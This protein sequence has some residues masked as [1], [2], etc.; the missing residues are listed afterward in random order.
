MTWLALSFT[1]QCRSVIERCCMPGEN[2]M[3]AWRSLWRAH[4]SSS[5]LLSRC[6][7]RHCS[8]AF[9][10]SHHG[11]GPN[12]RLV[13][14]QVVDQHDA[15]QRFAGG[16]M[17]MR[18]SPWAPMNGMTNSSCVC[19]TCCMHVAGAVRCLNRVVVLC[20]AGC[21]AGMC[22]TL[23]C[24]PKQAFLGPSSATAA[25]QHTLY[26]PSGLCL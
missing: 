21:C 12:A 18:S 9:Q 22:T 6:C 11:V 4:A 10:S 16:H 1:S 14:R 3:V 25:R 24:T 26:F 7:M 2:T 23:D 20:F 13:T 8:T 15:C 19:K 17:G 5:M